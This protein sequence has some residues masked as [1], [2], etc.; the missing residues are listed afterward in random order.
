MITKIIDY[1]SASNS[2]GVLVVSDN[3]GGFNFENGSNQLRALIPNG[4]NVEQIDR[5]RLGR[6]PRR[7]LCPTLSIDCRE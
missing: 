4:V 5:G 2:D 3:N 1:E 7:K 6:R